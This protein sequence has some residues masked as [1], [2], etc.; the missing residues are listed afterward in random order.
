MQYQRVI[1]V[2]PANYAILDDIIQAELIPALFDT[3]EIPA[4]F[5]R[6]FTLPV[7]SAG[8][9][10]LSPSAECKVNRETSVA[11]TR[12]LVGAIL[13][14]HDL[15][16]QDHAQQNCRQAPAGTGKGEERQVPANVQGAAEE[17]YTVCS[18]GGWNTGPRGEDDVQAACQAACIEVGATGLGHTTIC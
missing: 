9:G 3:D 8:I 13:Q 6:L 15:N 1:E 5:D 17:F 4:E 14:E 12:H 10:L 7:K 16:L 11:S 2:D 18:D